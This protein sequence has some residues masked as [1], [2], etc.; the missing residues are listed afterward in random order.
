V[1]EAAAAADSLNQQAG[2]MV[3][4]VSVF[5]LAEGELIAT[6]SAR[7]RVPAMRPNTAPAPKLPS[8]TRKLA[9][10]K[11]APARAVP[12]SASAPKR[13]AQSSVPA[14]QGGDDDWTTF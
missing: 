7:P 12:S 11:A 5:K 1:E 8:Q 13:L 3:E 10:Q 6:S 2:R 4:V 9:T 14:A